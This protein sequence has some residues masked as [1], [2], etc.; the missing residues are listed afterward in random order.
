MVPVGV[1]KTSKTYWWVCIVP[2]CLQISSMWLAGWGSLIYL[3]LLT[4][5][6]GDRGWVGIKLINAYGCLRYTW[7][8][9]LNKLK[10]LRMLT[11]GVGG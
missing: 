7:V 6:Y 5:T 11:G 4:D 2:N 8:G 3:I 1:S 10:C 9:G